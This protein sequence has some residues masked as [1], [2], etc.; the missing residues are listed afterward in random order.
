MNNSGDKLSFSKRK[1]SGR[2]K[3]IGFFAFQLVKLKYQLNNLSRILKPVVP[4]G[5]FSMLDK[6]HLSFSSLFRHML[7]SVLCFFAAWMMVVI[8]QNVIHAF[9]LYLNGI[10][11]SYSLFTISYLP[12]DIYEWDEGS[13]LLIYSLPYFGYL[14]FGV[15]LA[16]K[17]GR[18][19]QVSWQIRLL[20]IWISIHL[21]VYFMVSVLK[22]VIIYREFGIAFQWVIEVFY[23]RLVI[24]AIV[25]A[26]TSWYVRQRFAY[27][28]L[29]AVPVKI[30]LSSDNLKKS[31]LTWITGIAI[32]PG[33]LM[34]ALMWYPEMRINVVVT[35]FAFVIFVPSFIYASVYIQIIKIPAAG[36]IVPSYVFII[37]V[38]AAIYVI[39]K[40]LST[41]SYI[42]NG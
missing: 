29:T 30:F 23:L 39:L 17:T 41:Q 19:K 27:Y 16:E 1:D 3:Q 37:S 10:H 22:G 18:M 25:I 20:L 26:L 15:Y 12:G 33:V 40:L 13:M 36:K 28:F 32:I 2:I 34:A 35:L 21:I 31:W 9:L 24:A 4:S 14:M 7:F 42:I 38:L 6:A 8:F 11:F 5:E